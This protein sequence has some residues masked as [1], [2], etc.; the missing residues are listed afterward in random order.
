[1][2][3]DA[4]VIGAG[5]AG[6]GV[7]STLASQGQKIALAEGDKLGG[8]CLNYGCRPT[9]ALRASAVYA[10]RA[11]RA[12]E[13]GVKTGPVEVD[14]QTVMRRKNDIISGMQSGMRDYF[15][16]LDGVDIYRSYAH[17]LPSENGL[18]RV[19]VD[20]AVLE[21][22]RVF[23]NT[24]ARATLPPIDG[25]DGVPYLDNVTLL[26]LDRLPQHMIVLGGGYIGL[27]FG[28]MFRRFGSQITIVEGG[29]RLAHREDPEVSQA[30]EGI[31]ADDGIDIIHHHRM[32][33][34]EQAADGSIIATL[35]HSDSGAT[36]W[37][38]GSHVLIATGRKP[39]SDNLNLEAVG[40]ETDRRGYIATDGV[41]RTNIPGIWALGDVNGR[42]AFTHTSYQDYEILMDSLNG[43]SR[44]VDGRIMAYAMFTDPP[45]GRVGLSE[46]EAREQGF[47]Y[48]VNTIPM[49]SVSRAQLESETQGLL[50]VIVDADSEKILGAVTLG[51]HGDDFIQIFSSFMHT[52]ASY[53]IMRDALPVHPT[54][55]EFVPTLLAG[56]HEPE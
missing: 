54:V 20:G 19:Q 47:N 9:K 32:T 25:L 22:E 35:T 51:M 7:A 28:Q 42:G 45:L 26:E 14:F 6:P 55:A 8:T 5:Q 43:G 49:A 18:H 27:E 29:S 44:S 31:L 24:G 39:N 33:K 23:I 52:G 1:M 13:Y 15:E 10:H 17:F 12:A 3:Y 4:I 38:S 16:N 21:S 37:I 56:V 40:V 50:K 46:T 2:K 41:F 11:R 34:V 48:L 36:R 53:T 30:I